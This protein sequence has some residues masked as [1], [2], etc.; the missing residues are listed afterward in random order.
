[1]TDAEAAGRICPAC[2]RD[3]PEGAFCAHC[4]A[5]LSASGNHWAHLLRPKAFAVSSREPLG[6]PLFTSSLFPHL[7]ESLRWPFRHGLF[8]VLAALLVFS[9][10]EWL[11][12]LIVV[13]ILGVP[14]LFGLYVWQSGVFR[15]V[16]RRVL[17]L[18]VALGAGISAVW[19]LWTG[20][21]LARNYDI[22][23]AAASQLMH[24]LAFGLTITLAGLVLMLLPVVLVKLVR[25]RVTE[26]LDGFVIGAACALSYSAAGTAVWL[27]PQFT[28]GLIDN[29]NRW[30][31]LEEAYLYGFVEPVTAAVAG[32]LLGL[33][34][35]FRPATGAPAGGR[36][37]RATLAALTVLGIA[38][39]IGI[40][41]V[42]AAETARLTE[43]VANT[44]LTVLSLLALRAAVQVVL[45]S[46]ETSEGTGLPVV[47][48][49]CE[50]TVPDRPFCPG[51]GAAARATSRTTRARR[52][53]AHRDGEVRD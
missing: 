51:C 47:C 46:E 31:L 45:L 28:L 26:S 5:D 53:E 36:R 50:R 23:I 49:D 29:Y 1:M 2:G 14:L 11:A 30:L 7:P 3:A 8:L 41:L 35:W 39:Y 33:L 44:V 13:T 24:E 20:S 40:Y 4:G 21:L 6:L 42:D 37:A 19:W 22:P 43:I 16:S 10:L 12:P 18:A 38:L 9:M 25:S 27:L 15:D 34:L 17:L 32:G 52:F 48:E